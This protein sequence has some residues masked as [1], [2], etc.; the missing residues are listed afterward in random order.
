MVKTTTGAPE[1][2]GPN[3]NSPKKFSKL[4]LFQMLGL[5]S[6]TFNWETLKFERSPTLLLWCYL[7][8]ISKLLFGYNMFISAFFT[9]TDP[10]QLLIGNVFNYLPEKPKYVLGITGIIA[11]KLVD[12]VKF[13]SLQPFFTASWCVKFKET[14]SN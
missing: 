14:K 8:W 11:G 9:K 2:K 10:T 5:L 13:T 4:R 6:R 3:V 1:T 12:S 7:S